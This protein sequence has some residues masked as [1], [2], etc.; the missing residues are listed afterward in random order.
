MSI[1]LGSSAWA[2]IPQTIPVES[3]QAADQ[4]EIDGMI[5]AVRSTTISAQVA[6]EIL[7]VDMRAGQTV[8]AGQI[9]LRLDAEGAQRARAAAEAQARE[10]RADLALAQTELKRKKAL[11]E[12]HYISQAA[13]DQAR[14]RLQAI[15]ARLEAQ[16]AQALAA[17]AQAG[18]FQIQAPYDGIVN[19]VEA[20]PGDMAMPGSPLATMFDPSALRINA[21]IPQYLIPRLAGQARIRWPQALAADLPDMLPIEILPTRQSASLTGTIRLTLPAGSAG[22]APGTPIRL[23]IEVSDSLRE[24]LRIPSSAVMRRGELT[25]A[26]VMDD[27]GG[28][29]LRQI[30][31][32]PVDGPWIEVLTGLSAGE[33][34]IVDPARIPGGD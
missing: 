11:L 8:R 2:A 25:G 29:H 34:V 27:G 28:A 16:Q 33:R 12:Q 6:G 23:L 4:I 32:G 24:R 1:L 20:N 31:T 5:E 21:Q 10:T 26:Y 3:I 18:H 19:S 17:G 14:A 7:A 22:P 30:R 15:Q 13:Y 9:L